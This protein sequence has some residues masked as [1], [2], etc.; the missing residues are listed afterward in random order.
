MGTEPEV[1]SMRVTPELAQQWLTE[2]NIDNRKIRPTAVA[3]YARQ[4]RN[5]HWTWSND[6]L[7]FNG[8][9]R[10]LNGQHRLLACV[11][12]KVPFD[13]LV[14]WGVP[15]AAQEAMDT[16][17]RR[18]FSD[19]LA[20]HGETSAVVLA[21]AVRIG[22]QWQTNQL[23][24]LGQTFSFPE[25]LIWY[26]H[27]PSIRRCITPAQNI[28]NKYKSPIPA[29]AA[30]MHRIRLID[31]DEADRFYKDLYSGENLSKNDPVMALRN[32]LQNHANRTTRPPAP[33]YLAVFIK[34][35][36]GAISGREIRQLSFKRA[37]ANREELPALLDLN[38]QPITLENE[39]RFPVS[40]PVPLHGDL[41]PDLPGG[42]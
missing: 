16:G 12:S 1:K 27:N 14:V 41:G 35:W 31:P 22:W 10:L 30:F 4:M 19:V 15:S 29:T 39:R 37:K 38:H 24:G 18:Q 8:S 11:E 23:F 21:A 6:A 42:S 7:T 9:G 26:T 25:G 17:V 33:W 3:R 20:R 13:A 34:A 28:R 5:G 40:L 2:A 36:N 32:W